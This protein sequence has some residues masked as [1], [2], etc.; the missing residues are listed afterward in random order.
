MSMPVEK[1]RRCSI[2]EYLQFEREAKE[3]HEWRDGEIIAMGGGT[4]RHS[5]IIANVIRAVGNRL[6]GKPC[7]VYDSNLRVGIPRA[8]LYTYPD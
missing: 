8:Y 2:E 3:K 5:L 1:S 7:R 6:E 4:I